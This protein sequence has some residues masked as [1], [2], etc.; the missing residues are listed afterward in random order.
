MSLLALL[1]AGCSDPTGSPL[2]P[3]KAIPQPVPHHP[4]P[5]LGQTHWVPNQLVIRLDGTWT[6]EQVNA[7]CHTTTLDEMPT[8]DTY[9]VGTPSGTGLYELADYMVQ[10]GYCMTAEPNYL[11][12]SPESEQKSWAVY[13]GGFDHGDYVDQGALERIGANS[14]HQIAT[15]AGVLVAIV[16]TGIDLQ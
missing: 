6:I 5:P 13:E 1:S 16:D 3:D 4:L 10:F 8:E 12:E 2:A 9:L 15:G 7:A 14:A 11:L